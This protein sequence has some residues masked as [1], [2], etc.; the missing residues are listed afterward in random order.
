MASAG[1]ARMTPLLE[2][3]GLVKRFGGVGAVDGVSLAIGHR[4]IVG[5]IGPNGAGKTTLFNC[6]SGFIRPTA[7]TIRFGETRMD[8]VGR[9]PH[10]V[11]R[12]GLART[13]QNIRLFPHMT[14]LDNVIAGRHLLTRAG[15][16]AG[17]VRPR[18]VRDEEALSRLKAE[19]WLDFAGL[20]GAADRRAG[21]LSLG[22]QRRLEI[23]RAL[24]QEPLLLQLDE[25]AAGMNPRESADLLG[26]IGRIRTLGIAVFLI[27]HDMRV[28]MGI[29]DR[30]A[31][32]DHGV[33]IAAGTPDE[34]QRNPAVVEAYLGRDM[35]GEAAPRA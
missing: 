10:E 5:L 29:S 9:A 19:E 16:L 32:L 3:A 4:E 21:A 2:I 1:A 24:V 33:L 31:V 7:G 11:A 25:P 34:V 30:V 12:L 22:D 13:F 35:D 14:A 6:V 26:L 20:A 18:W 8:L 23:A 15:M 28:V 17:L 27:E